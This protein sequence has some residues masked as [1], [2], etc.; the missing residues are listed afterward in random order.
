MQC[1]HIAARGEGFITACLFGP[2]SFS[3]V[4]GGGKSGPLAQAERLCRG[5]QLLLQGKLAGRLDA[6]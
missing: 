5:Q 1:R 3:L 4:V 2:L 6:A